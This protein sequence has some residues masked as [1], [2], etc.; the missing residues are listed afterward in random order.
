MHDGVS[1]VN[2][3]TNCDMS[4]YRELHQI[5]AVKFEDPFNVGRRTEVAVDL[6]IM[7]MLIRGMEVG[8]RM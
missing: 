8:E 1:H 2:L 3:G 4:M 6:V 5:E 7:L